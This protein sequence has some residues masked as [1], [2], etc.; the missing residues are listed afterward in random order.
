MTE[1]SDDP[2][3]A[4]RLKTARE[5]RK[6]SQSQLAERAGLQA[7]AVSH[8]ETGTRKPS[9]MNLRR[10]A[11]ALQVSI[12]YLLGRVDSMSGE[13]GVD[14]LFRKIENLSSRDRKMIDA[15]ASQMQKS[16]E[17]DNEGSE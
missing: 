12:D 8:F 6:L 13:E 16:G 7:S 5:R 10:L 4:G 3:F 15:L 17:N 11:D 1:S 2:V 14:V 9:F